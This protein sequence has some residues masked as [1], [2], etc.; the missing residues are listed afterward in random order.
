MGCEESVGGVN[1]TEEHGWNR[2]VED[3]SGFALRPSGKRLSVGNDT[4][5]ISRLAKLLKQ[6]D[7]ECVVLEATDMWISA[8]AHE[9]AIEREIASD[10]YLTVAE[11]AKIL[12]RNRKTVY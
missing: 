11:L 3:A 7:P 12:K 9:E 10:E 2:R 4:R 1:G 5:G 6:V 8:M